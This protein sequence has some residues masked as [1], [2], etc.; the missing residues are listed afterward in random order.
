MA[1]AYAFQCVFMTLG[2]FYDTVVSAHYM[3]QAYY[4]HFSPIPTLVSL[5]LFI[6]VTLWLDISVVRRVINS[7]LLSRS[8]IRVAIPSLVGIGV[9]LGIMAVRQI[10]VDARDTDLLFAAEYGDTTTV[11]RLLDGGANIEARNVSGMTPLL[12]AAEFGKTQ[13]VAAL[14]RR[15]AY[16]DSQDKSGF[17]AIGV[18]AHQGRAQMIGQLSEL[19]ANTNTPDRA[20]LTPLMWAA[21]F[22]NNDAVVTLLRHGALVNLQDKRGKTALMM[23]AGDND[24]IRSIG[25][26]NILSILMAAGANTQI[27]DSNGS[28]AI[29]IALKANRT[30]LAAVLSQNA[31]EGSSSSIGPQPA[32][33]KSNA[34]FP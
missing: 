29:S 13:T 22:T 25:S 23:A 9:I 27:R 6:L 1:K 5:S 12:R 14:L 28:T 21:A 24:E 11:N 7:E 26:S 17:T 34:N 10:R 32:T 16:R 20:G 8:E 31:L 3:R 2:S 30:G 19:G 18:A 33:S 15:G 4:Y